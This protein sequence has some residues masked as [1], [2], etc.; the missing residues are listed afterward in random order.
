M[1]YHRDL[2][3]SVK[4]KGLCKLAAY[5]KVVNSLMVNER[6]WSLWQKSMQSFGENGVKTDKTFN[7]FILLGSLF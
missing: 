3:E 7:T 1:E 2:G 6:M 5:L 4:N